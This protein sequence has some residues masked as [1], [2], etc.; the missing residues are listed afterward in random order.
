M[1][2]AGRHGTPLLLLVAL[3]SCRAGST[4]EP[5]LVV[6]CDRGSS[7]GTDADPTAPLPSLSAA[8][9]AL[10]QRRTAA[11]S[12]NTPHPHAS[13]E[14]RGSCRGELELAGPLD[15]NVHW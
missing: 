14:V 11:A 9:D 8:R 12:S 7:G 4:T 6:D 3:I 13:I 10:R 15:A 2:G 1:G 5:T